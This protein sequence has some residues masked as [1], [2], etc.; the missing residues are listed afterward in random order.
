M[1]LTFE[2]GHL[3]MQGSTKAI[4][5][6]SINIAGTNTKLPIEIVGEFKDIPTD[7]HQIYIQTMMNSYG[8]TTV[9]A[10]TKEEEEPYPMTIKEQQ[11]EWRWNRL[12]KLIMKAITK[13]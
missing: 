7:L 3:T 6:A 9:Y 5:K 10:N 11:K 13:K 8:S 1:S 4:I 12:T 2:G